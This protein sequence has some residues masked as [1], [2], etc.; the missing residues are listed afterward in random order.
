[1]GFACEYIMAEVDANYKAAANNYQS[2]REAILKNIVAES[3]I[4]AD[5][6]VKQLQAKYKA[7][8]D[9]KIAKPTEDGGY[10]RAVKT[11]T[12]L[13]HLYKAVDRATQAV[14]NDETFQSTDFEAELKS[15]QAE[16]RT[17]IKDEQYQA[18]QALLKIAENF[19]NQIQINE[20]INKY[21]PQ[22]L[23]SG[24]QALTA[25]QLLG[26]SKRIFKQKIQERITGEEVNKTVRKHPAIIAG[27]LQEDK[28]ADA[29]L[30]L[31]QELGIISG[32]A[33]TVGDEKTHIDVLM[34][35][36]EGA[37]KIT[38]DGDALKSILYKLDSFYSFEVEGD[39]NEYNNLNFLGIQSKPDWNLTKELS[40][41]R[42]Y[43]LGSNQALLDLFNATN[44]ADNPYSWHQ[45]VLFLSQNLSSALGHNTVMFALG[46]QLVGTD[47]LL[48]DLYGNNKY[49]AFRESSEHLYTASIIVSSH[50]PP[51]HD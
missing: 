24:N 49:F 1:M 41:Y 21:L 44:G 10:G 38:Q 34:A 12:I 18:E 51:P 40:A 46:K 8:M 7:S 15:V 22:M 37:G 36:G 9:Q 50:Y 33:Q 11:N 39:S 42:S 48:R 17:K 25:G 3:Q 47:Q 16:S 23:S 35:V 26:Y 43:T 2:Q 32:N 20:I 13:N 14:I 5:E 6:F 28:L 30:Q 29:G 45:T 27:Y 19:A 4:S 31:L